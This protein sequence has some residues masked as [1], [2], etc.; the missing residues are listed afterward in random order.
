M[1]TFIERTYM[2]SIWS[3]YAPPFE[4]RNHYSLSEGGHFT[5]KRVYPPRLATIT[6]SST[7][8][9]RTVFAS[10]Q[11]SPLLILPLFKRISSRICH[12]RQQSQKVM[13]SI[14]VNTTRLVKSLSWPVARRSDYFRLLCKRA[15]TATQL[16]AC[17]LIDVVKPYAV[18]VNLRIE[19]P[20]RCMFDSFW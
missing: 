8:A 12:I 20:L 3:T 16:Q 2:A 19:N 9:S 5:I 15:P 14:S 10:R 17:S 7:S 4:L 1:P 18:L 11:P 6:S 13:R